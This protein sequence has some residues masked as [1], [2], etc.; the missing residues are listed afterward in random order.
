MPHIVCAFRLVEA[1]NHGASIRKP[2]AIEYRQRADP[3]QSRT[4]R[5][6]LSQMDFYLDACKRRLALIQK[7]GNTL[8]WTHISVLQ[9]RNTARSFKHHYR[10][11]TTQQCGSI[12]P[13]NATGRRSEA[14][15][16][17]GEE[18]TYSIGTTLM[19]RNFLLSSKTTKKQSGLGLCM[20]KASRDRCNCAV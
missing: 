6:G 7:F 15:A 1:Q 3:Q 10:E 4:C 20:F 14:L 5:R 13:A 16:T 19:T 18:P 8:L 12:L 17:T 2:L 9:L 11:S